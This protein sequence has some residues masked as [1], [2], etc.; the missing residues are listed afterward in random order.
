VLFQTLDDKSECV[1]VY[2]GGELYFSPTELPPDLSRTWQYAPYLRDYDI[3]YASLYLE[4]KKLQEVLPEYLQ[5]DWKDATQALQAFRRSLRIA[6]VN[7]REN[8]FYDLVPRRFLIEMCEARNAITR[9]VLDNVERPARY[10]F[11]K[12]LMVFLEDMSQHS[13]IID[14]RL[15][16]SYTEDPKL[17]HHAK[18]IA[19]AF[20][21]VR[22]NQFGTITGRLTGVRNFFPIL[23]LPREFRR[24]VR[25]THDSYVE[26]DFNG[27]EVRTLLGLLEKE[28]PEGDVH[29][30]HLENLFS[31]MHSRDEAKVAFFAWLYGSKKNLSP[32]VQ[33][34]LETFYQKSKLL[35]KHWHHGK[36]VTP[37][38]KVMEGVDHHHALNY[39]VQST[40]AEL[41]LKQAL[42]MDHL[43]RTQGSGSHIAFII[44]DAIVV[45]LK[46]EDAHL[47]PAL[48][49]LMA[50][51][52]FGKFEINIKQGPNLGDLRKITD[53]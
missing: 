19:D 12:R 48:K 21:Q 25:P 50:S 4:G 52:N 5:D 35:D 32:S 2:T 53:G 31:D 44:H 34:Q 45:D 3:E 30:Y 15:I 16:A 6:A 18:K 9:Y 27:A 51:T 28:Q 23:T 7:E 17:R 38:G 36:V 40:A 22:Y 20:P 43:L 37:Y 49:Y 24:A 26:L 33:S 11:Y 14:H 10:E 39:L 8:C 1:G 47:L 42:K 46:K 41:T 13:L 29:S